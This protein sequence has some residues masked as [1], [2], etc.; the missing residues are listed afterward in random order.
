MRDELIA[1]WALRIESKQFGPRPVGINR[2]PSA[3]HSE[4]ADSA[5]FGTAL[6][7]S[8]ISEGL[9]K[10]TLVDHFALKNGSRIKLCRVLRFHPEEVKNILSSI[11]RSVHQPIADSRSTHFFGGAA[12]FALGV[13]RGSAVPCE[14]LIAR[15]RHGE[16]FARWP[17]PCRKMKPRK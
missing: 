10:Q 6:R 14:I 11:K 16:D 5:H 15:L 2:D 1:D 7:R 17:L 4:F 3:L 12:G 13:D 9:L 8:G